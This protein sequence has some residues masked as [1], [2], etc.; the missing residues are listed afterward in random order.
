MN[1]KIIS[2][3][4]KSLEIEHLVQSLIGDIEEASMNPVPSY[5]LDDTLTLVANMK[6]RKGGLTLEDLELQTGLSQS[7]IKRLLK[8]PMRS[9]LENF[10]LVAGEL[11]LKIKVENA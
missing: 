5:P 11:G 3:R 7:T 8:N 9:S 4:A 10:L 1:P 2:L 6:E